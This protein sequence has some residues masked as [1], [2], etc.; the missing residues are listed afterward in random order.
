MIRRSLAP[1]ADSASIRPRH[2]TAP[3]RGTLASLLPVAVASLVL[4]FGLIKAFEL[5]PKWVVLMV[6]G[7]LAACVGLVFSDKRLFGVWML[8]ACIPIGFQY[9]LWT[10]GNKF[11]FIDHFGGALPEPVINLVD[12]PIAL[13]AVM[14]LVD[15]RLGVKP[16]PRWSGTDSL[17]VCL[18]GVSL[19]SL[20]ST[21]EYSLLAFEVFRYLK[22]F[23]VYWILRTYLDKPIY[24]WGVIAI[25]IGLLAIQGMVSLLQY[26]FF[27]QFPIP[28]GGVASADVDLVDNEIIQRV[29]GILGHCNTFAAYLSV[30]CSLCL[31]VVFARLR[32][33]YKL[34]VM[35]FLVAGL[36]SLV[37]TFSRNGWLVFALDSIA[38]GGWALRS[39]RLAFGYVAALFSAVLL[40]VGV[41]AATGVLDT[42]MTR[43]FRAGD[44]GLDSRFDLAGVAWEMI[45]ARPFTGIGL[46]SF[47]ENMT[48]YDPNHIAHIIRQPVHNAFLLVAAETGIPALL[49]LLGLLQSYIRASLRVLK[50]DD[51]LHFA[52]GLTGMATFCG[53]GLANMFDISLRKESVMGLIVLVAA[54]VVSLERLDAEKDGAPPQDRKTSPPEGPV[55]EAAAQGPYAA[56]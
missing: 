56:A 10:H 55:P 38:I 39:R 11:S 1:M 5:G 17:L 12:L 44:K 9:N 18:L 50:R 51:E 28:V 25:N 31:I 30:V 45:Q 13:L 53:L 54:M 47:E 14:W 43:V 8:A 40:T 6:L 2:R 37:L 15:L 3:F 49:L 27:F 42:I 41:L 33:I 32:G 29:T 48:L 34:A 22:Y 19:L 52:L 20:Y 7:Y 26:F 21:D 35:P 4:G 16:L 46:N 23:L 24:F 36:L